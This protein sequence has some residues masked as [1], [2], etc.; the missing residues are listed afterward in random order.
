MEQ[1]IKQTVETFM[2]N[3]RRD[4]DAHL[5]QLTSD[6]LRFAQETQDSGHATLERAVSDARAD[7]DRSFNRKLETL[8]AELAHEME[9]RLEADRSEMEAANN[10][11][12]AA[13]RE[14]RVETLDRLLGAARRIDEADTLSGILE[15][16]AKGAAAETSRVAL[17]LVEGETL[18]TWGHFGFAADAAPVD[19]PIAHAGV[20]AAAV[21]HRQMSFVP[22][23]LATSDP[24]TPAFMRVPA[25]H[26]GLVA[27]IAVAGEVVA[28]LYAD[29][30]DR[31]ASPQ[32]TPGWTEEVELLVRHASVRLENVTSE[33]AVEVL[34]RQA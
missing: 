7:A 14:G 28:L 25:G 11:L 32:D 3:V 12:R 29:D 31:L 4:L 8:R 16:L 6:L 15:A 30:A 5:R 17:L 13:Q 18:K 10:E 27:P 34:T 9:I 33:R 20:L 1:H 23:S 2:L 21:S 24:S 22:P 19:L 26:A